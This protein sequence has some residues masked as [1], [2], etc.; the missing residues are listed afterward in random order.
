MD[1]AGITREYTYQ[2]ILALSEG[3]RAEIIEGRWYDMAPPSFIHQK[4]VSIFTQQLRNYIQDKGGDCEVLP[5]PFGVFLTDDDRNYLEP[6]ISVV[7]DH[8]KL[9]ERGCEGAPDL[10][11]EIIS[12]STRDKDYGSKMAAYKR[13][14]V[15]EYWIIDNIEDI[16]IQYFFNGADGDVSGRIH[17]ITEPVRSRLYEGFSLTLTEYL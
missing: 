15:K 14:G 17:P 12:P 2:D 11:I 5:A 8:S 6:D 10:V 16:I 4:M 13:A 3:K 9:S 7:C 1:T